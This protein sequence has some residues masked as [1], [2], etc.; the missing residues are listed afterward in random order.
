ML[1]R[2]LVFGSRC[3]N[4]SITSVWVWFSWLIPSP[5][6][7]LQLLQSSHYAQNPAQINKENQKKQASDV[8]RNTLGGSLEYFLWKMRHYWTAFLRNSELLIFFPSIFSLFKFVLCKILGFQI[9]FDIFFFIQQKHKPLKKKTFTHFQNRTL[10]P[11]L[12]DFKS[13]IRGHKYDKFDQ[14]FSACGRW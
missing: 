8:S 7:H 3:H 5:L 11:Q 12:V 4:K 2:S 6:R 1:A 13:L 10:T 14:H 9:D